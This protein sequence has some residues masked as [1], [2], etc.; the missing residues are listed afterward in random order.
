MT[1][2]CSLA[3]KPDAAEV[4]REAMRKKNQRRAALTAVA[5]SGDMENA[6]SG[7]ACDSQSTARTSIGSADLSGDDLRP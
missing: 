5:Q 1:A 3:A 2:L 6:A 7:T 4:A